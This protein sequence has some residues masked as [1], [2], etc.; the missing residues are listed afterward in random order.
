VFLPR[1][2]PNQAVIEIDCGREERLMV[3]GHQNLFILTL[4]VDNG[5]ERGVGA[6]TIFITNIAFYDADGELLPVDTSAG[7]DAPEGFGS[8]DYSN[9]FMVFNERVYEGM[10]GS[11]GAWGQAISLDALKNDG[12]FDVLEWLVTDAVVT[13]AYVGASE[14]EMILQ[15]WSGGEGWAKIAPAAVNNTGTLAQ[16]IYA[17]MVAAFGTDDFSLV[18]KFY[19]GATFDPIQV[20][21]VTFGTSDF[22]TMREDVAGDWSGLVWPFGQIDAGWS[23]SCG[24]WGQAVSIDHIDNDG[25][26]DPAVLQP[27]VVVTVF[28]DGAAEPEMILQSWSGGSGW[29]KIAPFAVNSSGTGAQFGY[30][31]MAEAF[32]TD[33]FS[34]VDKFYIGATTESIT[35]HRV[36][37]GYVPIGGAAFNPAVAAMA[38]GYEFDL[39]PL[40]LTDA[41]VHVYANEDG[42]VLAETEFGGYG[43]YAYGVLFEEN[44]MYYLVVD[45]FD[46][47]FRFFVENGEIY[48]FGDEF[49]EILDLVADLL[50]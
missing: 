30:A 42:L 7:F 49:D 33:D 29:A 15:S 1:T 50:F 11:C 48:Y 9:L 41:L 3:P 39:S 44:G 17:D 23:G 36:I 35:V 32:G 45:G 4:E 18:D 46:I 12:P 2:N 34:L 43:Y 13:V 8:V 24:P 37:F 19:I 31:D 14:P 38:G 26:F 20:S 47:V 22:V 21:G 25:E 10:T 28:Y 16:F 40:G 6:G 5:K 27:G